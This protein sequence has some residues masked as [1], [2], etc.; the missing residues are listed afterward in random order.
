[1]WALGGAS[2]AGQRALLRV[3]SSDLG[4]G[5]YCGESRTFHGIREGGSRGQP[6]ERDLGMGHPSPS[7]GLSPPMR[8]G[9]YRGCGARR[10]RPAGREHP[11]A[12]R[13]PVEVIPVRG[14]RGAPEAG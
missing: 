5:R 9:S 14:V 3:L 10:G 2:A 1:M 4:L 7:T 13:H 8:E 12:P 11:V 6:K